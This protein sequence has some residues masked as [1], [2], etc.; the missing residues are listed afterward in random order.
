MYLP[1]HVNLRGKK[2]LVVGFGKVG[3][4]RVKKLLAAGAEVT[5]IDRKKIAVRG[6]AKFVQ[7]NL[8]AKNLPLF[9]EYFLVV[10][11]TD[12]KKLN[13]EI[14]K[15][16]MKDGCLVNRS[17]FFEGGNVIFP[18]VIEKDFG[19]FSFSTFGKNPRLSKKVKEAL[20]RGA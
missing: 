18:A 1:L 2:A 19:V 12:D 9:K 3:K 14:S 10:A 7:K 5:V 17:D 6:R 16:A 13:A 11:A 4:R 20:A 8:A 15:S